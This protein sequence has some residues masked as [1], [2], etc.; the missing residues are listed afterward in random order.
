M[1]WVTT[2]KQLQHFRIPDMI[3]WPFNLSSMETEWPSRS[4]RYL[5]C[6]FDT[7][8]QTERQTHR[9]EISAVQFWYGPTD[10]TTDTQMDR[11][12]DRH[13]SVAYPLNNTHCQMWTTV[14]AFT[15]QLLLETQTVYKF[16]WMCLFFLQTCR[17]E[18]SAKWPS[19]DN[20]HYLCVIYLCTWFPLALIELGGQRRW[21]HA[22]KLFKR[23]YIFGPKGAI[24]I[25][26]Y[27]YY[28]YYYYYF[29]CG[30][31]QRRPC[32]IVFCKF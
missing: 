19:D 14:S 15:V 5:R 20:W 12:T 1:W 9:C 4:M 28:Y 11:T 27:Y 8:K 22:N 24:Q 23:L 17:T 26:Y 29:R 10:R 16:H 25:C 30:L 13:T 6:R 31:S 7:D 3:F 21:L 32:V 2:R 18:L